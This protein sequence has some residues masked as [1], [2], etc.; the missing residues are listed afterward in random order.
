M[1]IE[2]LG[3]IISHGRAEMDPVKITGVAEWPTL[4]SKK[5]VQSFLGFTNFYRRFIQGFSD[6]A[7]P[8]FDLTQNNSDWHW[9]DLESSTFEAIQKCVVS[10]L[11]LMFPDDS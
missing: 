7:R 3:H 11:I 8:L 4:S 10:T 6:L 2:Y 1:K 5:E 9:R